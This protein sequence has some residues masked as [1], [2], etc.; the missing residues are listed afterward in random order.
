MTQEVADY[1]GQVAEDIGILNWSVGEY[2]PE[3]LPHKKVIAFSFDGVNDLK[4]LRKNIR[5][6]HL[7]GTKTIIDTHQNRITIY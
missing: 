5:S 1:L 7:N 4:R 3:G 6:G 2:H